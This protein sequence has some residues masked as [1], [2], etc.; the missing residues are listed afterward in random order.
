M[1]RK[2]NRYLACC[3]DFG[4][5]YITGGTWISVYDSVTTTNPSEFDVDHFVPLKEAWDSGAWDWDAETRQ[6]FANDLDFAPS[7]IAVSASSNRSKSASDVTEWLPTNQDY[8]C[9][10]AT[11]WVQ[12]KLRWSLSVDSAEESKLLAMSEACGG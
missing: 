4:Q 9:V 3:G 10:Y 7:L 5:C 2:R 8:W 1:P 12:V 11:S 6:A